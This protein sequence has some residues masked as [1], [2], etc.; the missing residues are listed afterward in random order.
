MQHTSSKQALRR[1][2]LPPDTRLNLFSFHRKSSEGA[3]SCITGER[4]LRHKWEAVRS[5]GFLSLPGVVR[6]QTSQKSHDGT[7]RTSICA[8]WSHK[9]RVLPKEQFGREVEK[10]LTAREEELSE[11]IY[12]KVYESQIPSSTKQSRRP[13]YCSAQTSCQRRLRWLCHTGS[14]SLQY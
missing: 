7:A 1:M 11:L 14:P 5:A 3:L 9:A 8:T 6:I 4:E 12:F 10:E 13:A 2:D